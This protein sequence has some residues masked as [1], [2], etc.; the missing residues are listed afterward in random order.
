MIDRLMKRRG[1]IKTRE[2]KY[3]VCYEKREPP[4]IVKTVSVLKLVGGEAVFQ[5]YEP[6]V[7]RLVN[8]EYINQIFGVEIPVLFL[9]W[10][11]A[12]WMRIKNRW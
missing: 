8:G 7:V 3:L 2:D 12:H 6:K 11:K 10:M 1:Y 5:S 9:M 4:N